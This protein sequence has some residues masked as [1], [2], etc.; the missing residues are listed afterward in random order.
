MLLRELFNREL[1]FEGPREVKVASIY[2]QR[3]MDVYNKKNETGFGFD[4]AESL[5][6]YMS[7][8]TVSNFVQWVVLQYINEPDFKLSDLPDVKDMIEEFNVKK[9]T[10]S[11]GLH[12]DLNSYTYSSLKNKLVELKD[13]P[14]HVNKLMKLYNTV[15]EEQVALGNGE[16]KFR[17][18]RFNVY[19]PLNYDGSKALRECAPNDISLCTT[20][21][22]TSMHYD[23]YTECGILDYVLTPNMLYLAFFSN[24]PD[25]HE[26]EFADKNN[27]H[28]GITG[29]LGPLFKKY[30]PEEI[31]IAT[32]NKENILY[33]PF[34]DVPDDEAKQ[35]CDAAVDKSIRAIKDVP[36]K[37]ID[38]EMATKCVTSD[39]LLLQYVPKNL[40]DIDLCLLAVKKM[41][42]ALEFVPPKLRSKELCDLAFRNTSVYSLDKVIKAIPDQF[43]DEFMEGIYDNPT[44]ARMMAT[45]NVFNNIKNDPK[46]DEAI[47][48]SVIESSTY[49]SQLLR[50][51]HE[52]PEIILN[53]IARD[54][55]RALLFIQKDWH[56][57]FPQAEP[58]IAKSSTNVRVYMELLLDEG[59]HD[60]SDIIIN[61]IAQ[62][63]LDLSSVLERYILR[64]IPPPEN[65]EKVVLSSMFASQYAWQRLRFKSLEFS[66][67]FTN[68]V[69]KS[70]GAEM[71]QQYAYVV[72]EKGGE[73]PKVI[74]Q[75][76]IS[77][78]EYVSVEYAKAAIENNWP[79]PKEIKDILMSNERHKLLVDPAHGYN[80]PSYDYYGDYVPPEEDD[81]ELNR[82]KELN[83]RLNR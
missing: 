19:T 25:D 38:Y 43:K 50:Q 73:I 58:V 6:E 34:T 28:E 70:G 82:V 54:P 26:S 83:E 62:N 55:G 81:D 15:M 61:A 21:L 79:I 27:N 7:E 46:L 24:N 30:L 76:M 68:Y 53:S 65:L 72:R 14:Y 10:A 4:D 5:V 45:N 31:E 17:S 49:A 20:F 3:L 40:R 2:G 74:V 59:L 57:Y 29:I 33:L 13:T 35:R 1:I 47:S 51:K 44:A 52:V 16:W 37:F 67:D 78:P 63:P 77:G 64:N 80:D 8:E 71:C 23:S 39:A 75:G 22:H 9:L 41:G 66:K 56:T 60:F 48:A 42:W 32:D 18:S 69:G 36:S 11:F 12:K